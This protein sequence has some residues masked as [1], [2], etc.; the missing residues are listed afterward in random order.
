MKAYPDG[1]VAGTRWIMPNTDSDAFWTALEI[2]LKHLLILD[3][4]PGLSV[5]SASNEQMFILD[6]DSWPGANAEELSAVF[7][8]FF[9]EI[10]DLPLQFSVNETVDHPTWEEHF[11]YFTQFPYSTHNT[12]GGRL[13]PRSLV[14]DRP[15]DLLAAFRGIVT[16]TTV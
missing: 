6:Y 10:K 5:N 15:Q 3:L 11:N 8:P 12:N 16:N 1:Q 14:R 9:E 7:V 4:T 13:I 2:W